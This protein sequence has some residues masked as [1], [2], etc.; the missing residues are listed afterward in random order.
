MF[1]FS[2]KYTKLYVSAFIPINL[3]PIIHTHIL[4]GYHPV[5][6]ARWHNRFASNNEVNDN[7]DWAV[8]NNDEYSE[9]QKNS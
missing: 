2:L 3:T 9:E 4:D 1:D 7:N 8:S 5:S 6:S